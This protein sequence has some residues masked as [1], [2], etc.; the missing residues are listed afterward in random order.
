[1]NKFANQVQIGVVY[2]PEHWDPSLWEE[3]V[4]LMKVTGVRVVRLAEFAW[5]RMEST[6]GV[7]HFEWL[8]QAIDLFHKY[9]IRVVLCTPTNTPPRWL[10]ELRPDV[11]PRNAD[12]TITY[13][14]VRGHRCYNSESLRVYGSRIIEEMTQRY[15]HHPAVIG[16]QTD[17]EYWVID[18][19]CDACDNKFQEW[20][21][22][23]YGTLEVVNREWG[24]VVWSGEYSDWSQVSVPYGGS[25]HQ[26]P[27][28]LLDFARFQWD[29]I[30][31]FQR[32]QLD[33]IRR[34]CPSHFVTHNFHTYPQRLNL[35]Q[36]GADL[37]F[38]SFDYYPNTAPDKQSTGPYSGALALDVTRGIKRQNFWIMEQLSGSPGCWFPTWR[39]PYPGFIRAFSW[40]AI[41]K[42]ADTVVHFRWRTAATGAEQF[43][44]GLI[45]P[46]NVPGRRFSEF[47]ELCGEV[48]AL[49]GKLQ[50]TAPKH[51]AAIL[52]SHEQLEALR[53]Q[54]QVEGMDYY[55]NVKDYHRALTKLGI[56]CDVIEWTQPLDG[57]K[58]VVAPSFYLLSEEAAA[59]LE[60]FAEAGGTVIIT[61][62]SGVKHMNNQAV[63]L[64]LPGLLAEC[65][66]VRVEE[67]DPIG[68]DKHR[69]V[70]S[71]GRSFTCSQWC[72]ILSL[73][74]AEAIAWY[75][76]DFYSGMP[77][78]TVNSFGG[79][80]VYYLGTHLEEAYLQELFEKEAKAHGMLMF[81]DL[82]EGVQI[83]VRSGKSAAYLFVLNL[84]RQPRQIILPA[85]YHSVLYGKKRQ[86]TLSMEPYGVD[87]LELT[88]LP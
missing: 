6:S 21:K 72:D 65:T 62:R 54:P 27:S 13:P 78:V 22:R 12:G 81:P 14:G 8:D 42:G 73:Q 80:R 75:D 4:Q 34:N 15:A 31:E 84:S 18:C 61:S 10:T 24:T 45:D 86:E 88:A 51:E 43:W 48:N 1:M 67:Y 64:P 71:E 52:L 56:G 68:Q 57:Y 87:V 41:A 26:N 23:K 2:Y 19:H 46:S 16:W 20:V 44:H 17:N 25:R 63:M 35:Y 60:R 28:Y 66:G 3:D 30:E 50:G 33:I 49:S 53:I 39:A 59:S 38:A 69:V 85:S 70:N 7:Y 29:S 11:L 5:S 40:Q 77:A 37:D 79:G 83:V 58:I 76:E 9:D 82:P 55:E 36:I 47:A 74:G 32:G